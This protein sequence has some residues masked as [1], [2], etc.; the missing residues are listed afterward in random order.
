MKTVLQNKNPQGEKEFLRM[1]RP[2]SYETQRPQAGGEGIGCPARM[3][4]DILPAPP[5]RHTSTC[6]SEGGIPAV[7]PRGRVPS[8][9]GIRHAGAGA[10]TPSR[11]WTSRPC[12]PSPQHRTSKAD[13]QSALRLLLARRLS[14]E[15][16][17]DSLV[18]TAVELCQKH[19]DTAV[20]APLFIPLSAFGFELAV[21]SRCYRLVLGY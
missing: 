18:R 1:V 7:R 21:L 5:R 11:L 13:S 19:A 8:E 17:A 4:R 3:F 20:R 9:F 15:W 16:S 6:A 14:V 12:G 2:G 10:R